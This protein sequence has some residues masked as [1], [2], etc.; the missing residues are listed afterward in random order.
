MAVT[1]T[2]TDFLSNVKV[3][4]HVPQGNSTFTESQ[5]LAL[6]DMQMR[7]LI[8]PAISSCRENYWLTT[9]R[10]TIVNSVN[11]YELPSKALGS[12][13]V[14]VK[15][16]VGTNLIHLIRMEVSDLYSTQFSSLPAYGYYIE[17]AKLKLVP[18]SLSGELVMWYYR[19]PSK[20]VPVVECAQVVDI[21]DAFSVEVDAVPSTFNGQ[22]LDI[23]SANP[24]FNTWLMDE[25]PASI[26]GNIITFAAVPPQVR[27]GDYVCL[28]GQS[29]VVQ[30]PLEW[31]EVLVQSVA[32]K[33]YEIQGY[34]RKMKMA[35]EV[36]QR[37]M[38]ATMGLVSP[39]T[40]ENSKVIQGGGSLLTPQ[41]MGWNLPARSNNA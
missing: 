1:Y 8:A 37:M 7:T 36:L 11:T 10:Q 25:E 19:I 34:D 29:C 4:S 23:V 20:L 31:V 38:K 16:A 5:L 40:V 21:P 41:N 3:V 30:C 15:V 24:G 12:S 9:Q 18:N 14:D 32:V 17:D 27:V 2:T 28:S 33:I 26:V 6:G 13:I 35:D 22:E 39:R